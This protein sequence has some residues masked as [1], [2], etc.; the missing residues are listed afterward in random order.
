MKSFTGKS[1]SAHTLQNSRQNNASNQRGGANWPFTP[2]TPSPSLSPV[3]TGT[4]SGTGGNR[5][6]T[7]SNGHLT[8]ANMVTDVCLVV[9]WGATIPGLMWLGTLGGF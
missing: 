5:G 1:Y 9:V 7:K 4:A 8:R 2:A 6:R 3:R